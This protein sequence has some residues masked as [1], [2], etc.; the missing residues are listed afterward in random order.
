MKKIFVLTF[1]I[2]Q[3]VICSSVY[4]SVITN[5]IKADAR[6][7]S[8]DTTQ[9]SEGVTINSVLGSTANL[10]ANN[11]TVVHNHITNIYNE[12]SDYDVYVCRALSKKTLYR[13]HTN[14]LRT[15][16]AGKRGLDYVKLNSSLCRYKDDAYVKERLDKAVK[17]FSNR[18]ENAI[19]AR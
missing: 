10:K 16:D 12:D 7:V 17:K 4:A 6:V 8:M 13:W 18:T 11:V 9:N 19:E 1:V 15:K 14:T 3:G 2:F 5:G